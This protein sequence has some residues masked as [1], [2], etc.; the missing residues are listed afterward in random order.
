MLSVVFCKGRGDSIG[1]RLL[2]EPAP[3]SSNNYTKN[4]NSIQI[5]FNM[6]F[7]SLEGYVQRKVIA[8]CTRRDEVVE[9]LPVG[10]TVQA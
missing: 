10:R 8:Y 3:C 2:T 9:A 7:V 4:S 1:M 6:L 5:D